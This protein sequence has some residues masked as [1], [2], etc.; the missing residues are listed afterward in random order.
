MCSPL[1][2]ISLRKMFAK[3]RDYPWRDNPTLRIS[4]KVW[5]GPV[6]S[7]SVRGLVLRYEHLHKKRRRVR[8]VSV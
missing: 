2:I 4:Q 1:V 7:G 5:R 6:S 3:S 8:P